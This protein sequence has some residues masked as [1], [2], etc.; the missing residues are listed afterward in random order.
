MQRRSAKVHLPLGDEGLAGRD[1]RRVV[2]RAKSPEGFHDA[3]FQGEL[4]GLTDPAFLPI[5]DSISVEVAPRGL[6]RGDIPL[7]SC[8][9]FGGHHV[10]QVFRGGTGAQPRCGSDN[11]GVRLLM[12]D[13]EVPL[14]PCLYEIGIVRAAVEVNHEGAHRCMGT[15]H[16]E[17]R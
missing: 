13:D 1:D 6:S 4:A 2:A 8:Q 9:L 5:D 14:L 7:D 16:I 10:L 12:T 17:K 3:G 11:H 15:V